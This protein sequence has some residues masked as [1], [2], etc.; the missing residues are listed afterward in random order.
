[1]KTTHVNKA[2]NSLTRLF[3]I[4]VKL[5]HNR[6]LSASLIIKEMKLNCSETLPVFVLLAEKTRISSTKGGNPESWELTL[7]LGIAHRL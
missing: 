3:T 7:Y 2:L 6:R 4:R 1:M 5:D